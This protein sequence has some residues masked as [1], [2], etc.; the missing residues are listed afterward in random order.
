MKI[1]AYVFN[2]YFYRFVLDESSFVN[3][4]HPHDTVP[5][6]GSYTFKLDLFQRPD[7]PMAYRDTLT[8]IINI[9]SSCSS[10]VT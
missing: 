9:L 2:D 6:R 1:Q 3:K 7:H 4:N 10:N 8:Q 5:L